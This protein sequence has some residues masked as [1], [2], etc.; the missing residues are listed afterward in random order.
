MLTHARS[1]GLLLTAL[2]VG[3]SCAARPPNMTT[4]FHSFPFATPVTGLA[5]VD[6]KSA[7]RGRRRRHRECATARVS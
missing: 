7:G 2:I 3:L 1:S 6:G 4:T 5:D